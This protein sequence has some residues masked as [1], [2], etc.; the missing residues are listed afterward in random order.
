KATSDESKDDNDVV[1][2]EEY[3]CFDAPGAFQSAG[4][5]RRHM[6]PAVLLVTAVAPLA[7]AKL[8]GWL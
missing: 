5:A 7:A 3:F 2:E 6:L 1:N 8:R 4:D